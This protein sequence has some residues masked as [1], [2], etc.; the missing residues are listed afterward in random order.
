MDNNEEVEATV[1]QHDSVLAKGIPV[2]NSTPS[3]IIS[4]LNVGETR[5]LSNSANVDDRNSE[6]PHNTVKPEG[7]PNSGSV[8]SS[9]NSSK[10]TPKPPITMTSENKQKL[11]KVASSNNS[12]GKL[13]VLP[14]LGELR[15]K[16][17][18]TASSQLVVVNSHSKSITE[19][20]SQANVQKSAILPK[21]LPSLPTQNVVNS[22]NISLPSETISIKSSLSTSVENNLIL[23]PA[24]ITTTSDKLTMQTTSSY[25]KQ[26]SRKFV[27][28]KQPLNS[29]S[30]IT[31]A[32]PSGKIVPILPKSSQFGTLTS[33]SSSFKI[34]TELP[35]PTE[36]PSISNLSLNLCKARQASSLNATGKNVVSS[37]PVLYVN[38]PT[39]PSS[40]IV[41]N[42]TKNASSMGRVFIPPTNIMKT[43]LPSN[44]SETSTSGSSTAK[45]KAASK[46]VQSNLCLVVPTNAAA[47]ADVTL[48]ASCKVLASVKHPGRKSAY[49]DILK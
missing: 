16:V 39:R 21:P 25:S 3:A 48:E 41:L 1:E 32:H 2:Q 9:S 10:I 38:A 45:S 42:P 44:S 36:Q 7:Y 13:M 35:S 8:A 23:Q 29:K 49:N 4:T 22:Q 19:E 47:V 11:I 17:I 6:S 18:R 40:D 33:V 31:S 26:C 46:P 30:L 15:L 24:S 27:I 12:S 20:T 5:G 14:T 28:L 43:S 37:T 34:P